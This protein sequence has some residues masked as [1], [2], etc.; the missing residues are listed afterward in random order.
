MHER[1]YNRIEVSD[2][3]N[4]FLAALILKEPEEVFFSSQQKEERN[5]PVQDKNR[6]LE[7]SYRTFRANTIGSNTENITENNCIFNHL[8]NLTLHFFPHILL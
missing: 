7:N 5:K 6:L 2:L 3:V 8:N 1:D 4:L